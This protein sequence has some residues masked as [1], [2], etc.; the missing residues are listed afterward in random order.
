MIILSID[1]GIKNLGLS[2][3]SFNNYKCNII[4]IKE[5]IPNISYKKLD[6]LY[7]KHHMN[8]VDTVIIEQQVKGNKNIF[9]YGF[10][11]SYFESKNKKVY[12]VKPYTYNMKIESYRQ[13]KKYTVN[14]LKN[15]I[16]NNI[17]N[18]LLLSNYTKY[19]DI[20]DSLC[21]GLKWL[22]IDINNINLETMQIT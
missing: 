8:I 7:I 15:I 17:D 1:V 11:Y 16:N 20:A 21:L 19:D 12:S 9:Y 6:K 22:K 18:V 5:S 13:R 2:L 4:C 10:I 3:I 14:I